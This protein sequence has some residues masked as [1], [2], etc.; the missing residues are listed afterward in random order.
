MVFPPHNGLHERESPVTGTELQIQCQTQS[1]WPGA[2]RNCEF[3]GL[4]AE[5]LGPR[6]NRWGL[7]CGIFSTTSGIP[8][9]FR[10]HRLGPSLTMRIEPRDTRIDCGLYYRATRFTL[11]SMP[12]I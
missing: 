12:S 3:V 9:D 4:I 7:G 5:I 2:G 8:V 11:A 6:R 10:H 1:P